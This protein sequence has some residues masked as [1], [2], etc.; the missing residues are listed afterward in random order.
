MKASFDLDKVFPEINAP[1]KQLSCGIYFRSF[2]VAVGP[3]Y[4]SMPM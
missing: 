3:A 1:A 2:A 4:A